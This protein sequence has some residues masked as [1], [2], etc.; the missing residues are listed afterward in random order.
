[1]LKILYCSSVCSTTYLSYLMNNAISP[2]GGLAGQKFNRLIIEGLVMN[3]VDVYTV[4][5]RPINHRNF[6]KII[7]KSMTE[8]IGGIEYNYCSFINLPLIRN[9]CVFINTFFYSWKWCKKYKDGVIVC[10]SLNIAVTLAAILSSKILKNKV[11]GLITD[12]PGKLADSKHG[13]IG[14][15]LKFIS[16]SYMATFDYYVLLTEYMNS[17]FNKKHKPYIIMEGLVDINMKEI[18]EKKKHLKEG[19]IIV[20]YAGQL[21]EIYGLK[22]M[23]EGFMA[24]EN[25]NAK[26]TIYGTG[27]FVE[28]LRRYESKDNRIEYRGLVSNEEI[29]R[30]EFLSTILINARPSYEMYTK[31]SFPSKNLEYMVSGTPV[32][33]SVMLGIPEEYYEYVYS[34]GSG[35]KEEIT[36][37]LNELF[38]KPKYELETMGLRAKDFV[39]KFKNNKI[40]S[41]R[42]LTLIYTY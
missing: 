22:N 11:I 21:A 28:N 6:N 23:V 32:L 27:S 4:S 7:W 17:I 19:K 1:M 15:V 36:H 12:I 33:T 16:M 14:C 24:T 9:I 2:I 20:M 26:F 31:Y 18:Q 8:M 10:Y 37:K 5:A 3:D 38:N 25:N 42:I 34:C 29:I 13:F 30:Q 41:K 40:Q 39:L 35:T